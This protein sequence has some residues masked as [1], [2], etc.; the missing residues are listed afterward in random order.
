MCGPN[1]SL[2]LQSYFAVQRARP[3]LI[4]VVVVLAWLGTFR[5]QEPVLH[6]Y[7][8]C[9][10]Q[11]GTIRNLMLVHITRSMQIYRL[12]FFLNCYLIHGQ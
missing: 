12:E 4:N 6:I 7:N 2:I 10:T 8:P 3:R 5:H 1:E 9:F 11:N